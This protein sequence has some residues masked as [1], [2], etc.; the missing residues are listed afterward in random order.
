MPPGLFCVRA[1]VYA[2]L[3]ESVYNDSL[4]FIFAFVNPVVN[5]RLLGY[6]YR[7][8]TEAQLV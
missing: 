8:K 4:A 2:A 5:D 7:D 3:C 6:A 1:A